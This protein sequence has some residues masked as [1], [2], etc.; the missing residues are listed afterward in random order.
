MHVSPFVFCPTVFALLL[1]AGSAGTVLRRR[2]RTM[3]ADD[4]TNQFTVLQTSVL[5]LLGLLLGFSFSMAVGRFDGR[6]QAEVAEANAIRTSF[7]R[8]ATLDP[9][10]GRRQR[11]AMREYVAAR[12]AFYEAGNDAG[13]L[14]GA[15]RRTSELEGQLWENAMRVG[16]PGL[17]T[18]RDSPVEAYLTS[19]T[20][21]FQVSELRLVAYEN[22]IPNAAWLL[23]ISVACM[24]NFLVGLGTWRWNAV[25]LVVLPVVV[26]STLTLVYDLD[27]PRRGL[28]HVSQKSM[29]RVQ[30]EVNAAVGR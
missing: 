21:M 30:A 22:R 10:L 24:A 20:E 7:V 1:L 19:L 3:V 12:I 27:V 9:E 23:L 17:A 2:F 29:E 15:E 8:T 25:L 5:P 6:R 26:A 11:S 28:I 4:H 14:E 13:K 18:V 16:G